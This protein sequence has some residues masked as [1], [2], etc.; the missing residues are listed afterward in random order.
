MAEND[1]KLESLKKKKV[2]FVQT[3]AAALVRV[4]AAKLKKKTENTQNHVNKRKNGLI[5]L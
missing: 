3:A 4:L 2:Q 1:L 5:K